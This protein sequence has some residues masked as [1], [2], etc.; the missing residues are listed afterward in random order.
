MSKAERFRLRPPP[1][2]AG[3]SKENFG[4]FAAAA[5]QAGRKPGRGAYKCPFCHGYHI[6]SYDNGDY[7]N[8][9]RVWK[10]KKQELK[11]GEE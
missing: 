1:P 6:G 5:A 10:R 9:L 4:S 3:C 8:R 7:R 2:P 11:N